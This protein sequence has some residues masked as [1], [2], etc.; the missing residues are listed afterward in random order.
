MVFPWQ[1]PGS[2][3]SCSLGARF[4]FTDFTNTSIQMVSNLFLSLVSFPSCSPTSPIL[5]ETIIPGYSIHTCE[6]S[7]ITFTFYPHY[8]TTRVQMLRTFCLVPTKGSL[9]AFVLTLL[10]FITH[11]TTKCIFQNTILTPFERLSIPLHPFRIKQKLISVVSKLLSVMNS[12][13]LSWCTLST[14]LSMPPDVASF[15]F[16][17]NE[18]LS[19]PYLSH[20]PSFMYFLW[21]GIPVCP[22]LP[23]LSPPYPV[24][25]K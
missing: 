25:P 9:V 1:I 20:I 6:I 2:F 13:N 16:S 21:P 5:H 10:E 11:P 7:H 19:V 8:K 14:L 17:W 24:K 15:H 18:L 12:I 23:F 3:S 4:N 22:S